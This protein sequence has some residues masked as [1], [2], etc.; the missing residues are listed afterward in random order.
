MHQLDNR[1]DQITTVLKLAL[2]YL[3]MRTRDHY[4]G[5]G[6]S[7]RGPRYRHAPE[8]AGSAAVQI[9][10]IVLAPRD[11]RASGASLAARSP[12]QVSG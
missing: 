7:T 10:R 2:T 9:R 3:A 12:R 4:F 6:L 8:G 1:K 5:G 11:P